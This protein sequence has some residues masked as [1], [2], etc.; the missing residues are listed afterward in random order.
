MKKL[1]S[2]GTPIVVI[3][4]LI[5]IS[6]YFIISAFIADSEIKRLKSETVIANA[7]Y[8]QISDSKTVFT[9]DDKR[10]FEL[11]KE[12]EQAKSQTTESVKAEIDS[13]LKEY[14]SAID[15]EL[16]KINSYSGKQSYIKERVSPFFTSTAFKQAGY[17][18]IVTKPETQDATNYKKQKVKLET[19]INDSNL[20]IV[21]TYYQSAK[22][23]SGVVILKIS[24]EYAPGNYVYQKLKIEKQDDK[25]IIVNFEKLQADITA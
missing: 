8:E 2:L 18:N 14:D 6:C 4:S 20:N 17:E 1:F 13:F 9:E 11:K 19:I 22:P 10:Y 24:D 15:Y 21:R 25:Y 5:G 16:G 7:E 23:G 3:L 12:L